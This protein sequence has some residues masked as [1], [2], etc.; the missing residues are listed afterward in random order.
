MRVYA[1]PQ[2]WW[3]VAIVFSGFTGLLIG[4]NRV[5]Y[6]TTQTNLITLGYFT[7]ALYWMVHR[8]TT[9]AAAP[10]LRG[11]ITLWIL[12]TG[13]ISH[14]L[15]MGGENP[16]PGLADPDPRTA[17]TNWTLFLVHYVVPT[18]VVVDWVAFGPHRVVPWRNLGLWILFPLGYGLAMEIRAA[19]FPVVSD[20]YPYFFLNPTERGF[21]W[22]AQQFLQLAVIFTILAVILLALDRLMGRRGHRAAPDDT[23]PAAAPAPVTAGPRARNLS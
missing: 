23:E 16:L 7:C 4:E 14:F 21:P 20:R 2:F 19:L 17:L 1:T 22:V 8:K 18:L 6:Y 5:A 15:L 13:L 9:D 10:R 3:R 11:A 12:I